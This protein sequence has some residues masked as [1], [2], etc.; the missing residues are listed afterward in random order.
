[1][2]T[3]T[4]T[5]QGLTLFTLTQPDLAGIVGFKH[6]ERKNNEQTVVGMTL[7]LEG[8]K[9]TAKRLNKP[10]KSTEVSEEM[11]R[12]SNRIKEIGVAEVL[13]MAASPEWTGANVRVTKNKS[14]VKRFALAL[15]SVPDK[16]QISRDQ[17]A[18][19]LA[20]MTEDEQ[21]AIMEEAEAKR[22]EANAIEA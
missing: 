18:K 11:L 4:N 13:K 16:R 3:N 17:L 8:K 15:V 7:T 12:L 20:A 21:I 9:D 19:A 6:T 22:A 14:G 10:Q 1:M 2:S 5:E